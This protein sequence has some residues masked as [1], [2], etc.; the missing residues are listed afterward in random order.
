M[1]TLGDVLHDLGCLATAALRVYGV[2]TSGGDP[3]FGPFCTNSDKLSH[4]F[5]R[6]LSHK[7][8]HSS[9]ELRWLSGTSSCCL[10]SWFSKRGGIF[11]VVC[12]VTLFHSGCAKAGRRWHLV[13]QVELWICHVRAA[14][15][16]PCERA[17]SR[18]GITE[19]QGRLFGVGGFNS[20]WW[21]LI[22]A[23][24]VIDSKIDSVRSRYTGCG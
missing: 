11:A 16:Y 8:F 7:G 17:A 22:C 21:R 4:P 5:G 9:G 23:A 18:C 6:A 12:A 10:A 19:C 24:L 13:R 2:S 14:R 3:W 1:D 15:S 20:I